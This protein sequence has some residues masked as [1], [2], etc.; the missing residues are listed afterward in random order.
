MKKYI[1]W[2]SYT[3]QGNYGWGYG[4]CDLKFN[5]PIRSTADIKMI[6]DYINKPDF[7]KNYDVRIV[8][9]NSWQF[10]GREH[11][12]DNMEELPTSTNTASPKNLLTLWKWVIGK[13]FGRC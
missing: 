1:Y 6:V 13:F 2:I 5:L 9:L 8:V 10:I 11:A 12:Q 4:A 7:I 3:F